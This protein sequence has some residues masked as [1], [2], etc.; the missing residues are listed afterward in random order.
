[1][2]EVSAIYANKVSCYTRKNTDGGDSDHHHHHYH[3]GW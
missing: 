1:M 2:K 3:V